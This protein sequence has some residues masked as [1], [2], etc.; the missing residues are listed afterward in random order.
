MARTRTQEV[1]IV[2]AED[3]LAKMRAGI[4]DVHEIRMRELVVP[5]R[6][7]SLSEMNEI[8]KDALKAAIAAQ[9]D[10]VDKNVI[11]QKSTLKLASTIGKGSGPLLSDKLLSLLTVDEINYLYN[12]YIRVNEEVNPSVETIEPE[13]F[14]ALVD[15]LKKNIITS[16]DCSLPQLK[17]IC[18]AFVDLILR[19]E[20]QTSQTVN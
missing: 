9:G 5:V 12:E 3:L 16:K 2:T 8:R 10:E 4:R 17:A 11:T 13:Q 15:A 6:V 20:H 7:L 1:E 14:R 18:T 19:M